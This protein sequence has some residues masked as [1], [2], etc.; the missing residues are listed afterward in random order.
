M[1]VTLVYLILTLFCMFNRKDMISITICACAT[2]VLQ[3]PEYIDRG[4]FRGFVL[5]ILVSWVWDFFYLFL[6]TSA[7]D[8][9]DEDGGMEYTVRRFSRLFAYISFFFRIV[10]LL[11]FWKDSVDF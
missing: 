1:G 4:T 11:V 5:M 2:Y 7:A 9:D 8:E 3:N 6:F 10:V